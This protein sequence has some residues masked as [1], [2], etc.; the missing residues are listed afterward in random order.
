MCCHIC[1]Y[2]ILGYD[3]RPSSIILRIS[4][5][6]TRLHTKNKRSLIDA[7][8]ETYDEVTKEDKNYI[9]CTT[10]EF[11]RGL[12]FNKSFQNEVSTYEEGELLSHDATLQYYAAGSKV[13]VVA[14]GNKV[15]SED[16]IVWDSGEF[17]DTSYVRLSVFSV[18]ESMNIGEKIS[19]VIVAKNGD[20]VEDTTI[21]GGT[22]V[23]NCYLVNS[24]LN[25]L[26]SCKLADGVWRLLH[27]TYNCETDVLGSA[28]I[29]TLG[30]V[31]MTGSKLYEYDTT[32]PADFNKQ[33][34]LNASFARNGNEFYG[35]ILCNQS[36]TKGIV[37][38]TYNFKD[39]TFVCVPDIG[40]SNAYYEGAMGS[41]GSSLWL[42][43]RQSGDYTQYTPFILVRMD[44]TGKVL[45]K[46][47]IYGTTTS[48]AQFYL[49]NMELYLILP[50]FYR[51]G[52]YI[53][54]IGRDSTDLERKCV[55]VSDNMA[56]Q[57]LQLTPSGN[58]YKD[59]MFFVHTVQSNGVQTVKIGNCNAMSLPDAEI[60]WNYIN[61]N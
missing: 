34:S 21:L 13:Y 14:V 25:I 46:K 57:Y 9:T 61:Q 19:S 47:W 60:Y 44:F 4:Q 36:I 2:G 16:G 11:Y 7:I 40:Y 42:V 32:L 58:N 23:P 6:L 45:Y 53:Y 33:I 56:G 49:F 59:T 26:L 1:F 28:E 12:L 38:R 3:R 18:D 15:R 24:T 41:D 5:N 51:N 8:N 29:C 37:V 50:T 27:Y 17:C 43:L 10:P 31:E 35:C 55:I 39:Y 20:V 22:G 30:G 54:K 52:A 48:R